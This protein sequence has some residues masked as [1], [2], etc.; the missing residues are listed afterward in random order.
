V[1]PYSLDLG[2]EMRW[3]EQEAKQK[4]SELVQRAVDE[5][6]QTVTRHGREVVVVL[7]ATE[8]AA[9]PGVSRTSRSSCCLA[10]T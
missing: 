7:A 5:G 4:F 8:F 1:V 2:T 6:P 3:Q 9:S 10:R